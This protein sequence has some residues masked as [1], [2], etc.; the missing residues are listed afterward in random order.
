MTLPNFLI[1]GAAKSG[2]SSIYRYL[3]QHP[4]VYMSPIKEPQFFGLENEKLVFRGRP[5]SAVKQLEDY[6]RLFENADGHIAIG[7]A[8]NTYL[9][10]PKA[11][12]NI[13]AHIPSVKLIAILRNPVERAY[14]SYLHLRR[15]GAE[16]IE[17]FSQAL[18]AEDERIQKNWEYLFRYKNM[19]FYGLQLE[20]YYEIF[21]S[22]QIKVFLYEE[23]KN[24]PK[25]IIKEM[26]EFLN[27][28]ISFVPNMSIRWNSSGLPKNTTIHSILTGRNSLK[29]VVS[30]LIPSKL[31]YYLIN[32]YFENFLEKPHLRAED[33]QY[34]NSVF[35]DDIKLLQELIGIDVSHWC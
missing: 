23:F 28:D 4:Q 26:F 7:E 5:F 10:L 25:K 27:V 29:R 22:Q 1:I 16:S 12:K 18:K 8:S 6:Y 11:S 31:R 17:D 30:P 32:K 21:D 3:L 14:S 35:K 9:Y 24:S 34:L 33:R 2:T 15:S 13:H 20:R 19:G